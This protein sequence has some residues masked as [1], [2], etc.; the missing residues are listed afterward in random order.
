MSI[1]INC[2]KVS[3]NIPIDPVKNITYINSADY[4]EADKKYVDN[5]IKNLKLPNDEGNQYDISQYSE[6]G[7][8]NYRD[9]L[10]IVKET[11]NDN[12]IQLVR[13]NSGSGWGDILSQ[14]GDFRVCVFKNDVYY[15]EFF[16]IQGL[17]YKI[18]IPDSIEDTEQAYINYALPKVRKYINDDN[19]IKGTVTLEKESGDIYRVLVNGENPELEDNKILIKKADKIVKLGDINKDGKIN[20]KDARETLLAYIGKNKLTEEQRIIAD[21]NKDGKINTKDARQILLYYVGAIKQF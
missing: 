18:T 3:K 16:G 2:D 12:S 17:Y 10:D 21:V 9:C 14:G 6:L 7:T 11:I 1:D 5:V 19:Q 8:E 4:N 20:T 15:G 13:G